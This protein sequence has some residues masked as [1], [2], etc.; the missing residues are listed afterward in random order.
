MN[1]CL[2]NIKAVCAYRRLS[3]KTPFV[4]ILW[5]FDTERLNFSTFRS[6]SK[7][8]VFLPSYMVSNVKKNNCYLCSRFHRVRNYTEL[9]LAFWNPFKDENISWK[10]YFNLGVFPGCSRCYFSSSVKEGSR[11]IYST[12]PRLHQLDAYVFTRQTTTYQNYVT[13]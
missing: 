7:I 8:Q 10:Y 3:S 1:N 12:P 9:Q 2:I 6:N 4:T 11:S 13:F 5:Q